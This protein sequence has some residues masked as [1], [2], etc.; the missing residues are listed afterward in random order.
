MKHINIFFETFILVYDNFLPKVKVRIKAK[1][2]NSPW[3]TKGTLS[4]LKRS[5]NS[6]KN[7]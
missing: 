3:T 6:M 2:L 5:K 4:L 7:I 1:S